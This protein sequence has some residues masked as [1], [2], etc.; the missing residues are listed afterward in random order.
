M[1]R[2]RSQGQRGC[3]CPALRNAPARAWALFPALLWAGALPAQIDRQAT[4]ETKVLYYNLE[5]L[6]GDYLLFGHQNTNVIG[7]GWLDTTGALD[8]SDVK[9]GLGTF[10]AVFGFDF[11]SGW[12][13]FRGHVERAFAKGA[14]ITYSWHAPNP[15]TGGNFYDTRGR[16][17]AEI[18][19]GG[20]ANELYKSWLRGIAGF[21][22]SL[23]VK[24]TLVPI[25]FRPF[26]ENTGNW[27]WW[28]ANFCTPEEFIAAWRYTV[29]FLRDTLGV[30]NFL[31]VYSPDGRSAM[32]NYGERYPGDDYVDVVGLDMYEKD[33]YSHVLVQACRLLVQFA[34]EHGKVAAITETGTSDGLA[35]TSIS[36]WFT[37]AFLWPLKAD[38]VARK[39]AW[40]LFWTNTSNTYWIP[41]PGDPHFAAFVEFYRDPFVLFADELPNLYEPIREDREPPQFTRYP[42][43]EFVAFETEVEV[44]V[45]TNERAYL[46]YGTED[47]PYEDLPYSFAE[48]EGGVRHRVRLEGKHGERYTYYVRAEDTFGNRTPN[49]L[50]IS[51]T[52]D[53]TLRQV[54]WTDPE[55][56]DSAWKEGR[57]PLGFGDRVAT[58]VQAERTVYFRAAFELPAPVSALGVLVKGHDGAAVYVNGM[59]IGRVQIA[60][61][62]ALSPETP[63]TSP[64]PFSKVVVLG[65]EA[66]SILRTGTN[67][68]AV[69]VH[70]YPGPSSD[71]SFDARVFNNQGIY[72]DLGSAWRYFDQGMEPPVQVRPKGTGVRSP[73]RPTPEGAGRLVRAFRLERNPVRESGHLLLDLA[74]A[75]DVRIKLWDARG[76]CVRTWSERGL[77]AGEHRIRLD[78]TDLPTGIYLVR[79]EVA[80]EQL[81]GKLLLVK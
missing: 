70:T 16:P 51:F 3:L 21:A 48:G 18:V 58:Q 66:R 8:T 46:R 61:G 53:T 34:E 45:W 41:L 38:P 63:A 26:H 40:A 73:E 12:D 75:A 30:H 1:K 72:L 67:V 28:G 15:I 7:R 23:R 24:G 78:T 20:S 59:E 77:S 42:E 36:D 50:T 9:A 69:E 33:D 60:P 52:V 71:L 43:A 2:S 14:V 25:L 49:P 68:V 11:G 62:V 57:A 64:V 19:P 47:R 17:I 81:T 22:K 10:P 76:R 6:S 80:G 32:S 44:E 29:H 5:L 55:F 54:R 79:A 37:R 35:G 31:Y 4:W 74:T 56:D 65:P 13:A 27:F 39:V